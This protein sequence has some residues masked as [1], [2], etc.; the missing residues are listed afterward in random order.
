MVII[1]LL[2]F[3]LICSHLAKKTDGSV[4][5]SGDTGINQLQISK[6]I[7]IPTNQTGDAAFLKVD[8]AIGDFVAD[9]TT[10]TSGG[11]AVESAKVADRNVYNT[12]V[13][14]HEYTFSFDAV[15]NDLTV[16]DSGGGIV[17]PAAPY[18]AGGKQLPL[19]VLM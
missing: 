8:N 14:P 17:F 7:T 15:T 18:T 6:N 16:T 3:K 11:V 9:Y 13:T 4:V 19:T 10:N 2:V 5:Y 12:A 1:F